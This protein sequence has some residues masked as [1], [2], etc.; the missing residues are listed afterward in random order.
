M[1]NLIGQLQKSLTQV[2]LDTDERIALPPGSEAALADFHKSLPET[3]C[4]ATKVIEDLLEL[5]T[6]AGGNTGGPRCFHFIIGGSTPTALAADLLATAYETV[7]YTWVLPPVGVQME[8][9]P[10]NWLKEIF[11]LPKNWPGVM[12]TGATMVG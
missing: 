6:A 3:G 9:Q 12:V 8:L 4:G 1:E 11:G 5:N 10:L 7:T 2:I